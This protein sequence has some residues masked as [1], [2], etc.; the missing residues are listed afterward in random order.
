MEAVIDN[1]RQ[2]LLSAGRRQTGVRFCAPRSGRARAVP[3]KVLAFPEFTT[4]WQSRSGRRIGQG[5]QFLLAVQARRRARGRAPWEEPGRVGARRDLRPA[6]RPVRFLV[7]LRPLGAVGELGT[8]SMTRL[9]RATPRGP[10]GETLSG[11]LTGGGKPRRPWPYSRRCPWSC[12]W[13]WP[14]SWPFLL[15]LPPFRVVPVLTPTSATKYP[16][17]LPDHGRV[18]RIS[19][20][21]DLALLQSHPS[22]AAVDT[23]CLPQDHFPFPARRRAPDPALGVPAL[24]CVQDDDMPAASLVFRPGAG[25]LAHAPSAKVAASKPAPSCR[26]PDTQPRPAVRTRW[27]RSMR[28]PAMPS[29]V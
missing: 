17:T 26:A 20:R 8:P 6:S 16:P 10:G 2:G 24:A 4:G 29:G 14:C 25:N 18:N 7:T 27:A 28:S 12:P 11:L 1:A 19:W 5:R 15:V 21:D 23:G 13:T 9:G 22:M 3:V